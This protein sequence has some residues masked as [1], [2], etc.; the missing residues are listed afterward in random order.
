[1][2]EYALPTVAVSAFALSDV[3]A[4]GSNPYFVSSRKGN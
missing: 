4:A 1:M 2:K 3:V